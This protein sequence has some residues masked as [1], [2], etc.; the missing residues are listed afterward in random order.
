MYPLR[1]VELTRL[2]EAF[3]SADDKPRPENDDRASDV[4]LRRSEEDDE[5]S[6]VRLARELDDADSERATI[7]P[8]RTTRRPPRSS[9][10][11][12][13][14]VLFRFSCGD[15]DGALAAADALM[16][17][18]PVVIMPR[19]DLRSEPLGYWALLLLARIDGEAPLADLLA[20]VPSAEAVRVVCELVERRI[21]ALR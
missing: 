13:D 19:A 15:F 10:K 9:V 12:L 1:L 3:A 8:P 4:R 14:E 6:G 16:A 21:I 5:S 2:D 7:P 18:V 20:D 11:A 17:S